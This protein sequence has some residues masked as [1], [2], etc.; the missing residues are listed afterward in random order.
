MPRFPQ[1][2]PSGETTTDAFARELVSLLGYTA[3]DGSNNAD[4]ARTHGGALALVYARLDDAGREAFVSLASELLSE[5]E[6]RLGLP[7]SPSLADATRQGALTAARRASA[8]NSIGRMLA[9]LSVLDPT[10][11]IDRRSA[12][13]VTA[14]P[15]KVF[16]ID[17]RIAPS[18][19]VDPTKRGRIFSLV[20]RM[21]PA[22]VSVQIAGA[23]AF[24]TDDPASLTDTSGDVLG[25]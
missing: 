24:R 20:D 3:P 7:V 2:L 21:K 19:Y 25:V 13:D 15:R 22:H 16:L 1:Q 5:W 4:D 11:Q 17:V 12:V 8:G 10:V 23:D 6:S 9:A 18:I 14:V